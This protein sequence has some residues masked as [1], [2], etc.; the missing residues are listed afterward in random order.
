MAHFI[1]ML[2]SE[3]EYAFHIFIGELSAVWGPV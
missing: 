1:R 2:G 3:R